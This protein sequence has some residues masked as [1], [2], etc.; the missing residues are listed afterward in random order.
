MHHRR[1]NNRRFRHRSSNRNQGHRNNNNGIDN[2][3]LGAAKFSNGRI[4]NG[5]ITLQ[6]AEKLVEKYN[7][8]A[9]EALTSG[10][11]TLSENYYQHADHFM[12]IVYEKS[13]AQKQNNSQINEQKVIAEGKIL[14]NK[15]K[16]EEKK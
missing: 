15:L 10:D 9:K 2:T 3:R 13:L 1:N 8:L 11:R 14:T 5:I 4:R 16:E 6:S 12:R 7:L